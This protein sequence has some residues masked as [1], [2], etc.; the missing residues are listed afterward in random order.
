MVSV[1]LGH[2]HVAASEVRGD[3]GDEPAEWWP[4]FRPVDHLV[5]RPPVELE[6]RHEILARLL[7]PAD[8]ALLAE[9]RRRGLEERRTWGPGVGCPAAFAG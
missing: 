1:P 5:V 3:D 2:G 6:E 4:H 9:E 7:R 8:V